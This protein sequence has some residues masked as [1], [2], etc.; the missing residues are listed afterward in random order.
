MAI[1]M[2]AM[3]LMNLSTDADLAN[4]SRGIITDILLDP[5]EPDAIAI[6]S[7][8]DCPPTVRLHYPPVAILFKPLNRENITLRGLPHGTI[9]IT[10]T[11]KTFTLPGNR[12]DTV[13]RH[14]FALTPAYAFTDF[15]SQG[16]TMENVIV[17]IAKPPSGTFSAFNAYVALS[18]SRGRETIR[19]LRDFEER[20][21]TVHPSEELRLEDARLSA[22]EKATLKRYNAGQ[23]GCFSE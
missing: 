1:G 21:F 14:Q 12:K 4:G 3:V 23:Y 15:K 20:L 16:Q 22:L 13:D 11:H 6:T 10:P 8:E 2:K 19:L 7:E 17:D 9:P 5:R 18:R